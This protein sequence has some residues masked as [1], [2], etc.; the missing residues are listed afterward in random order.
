MTGAKFEKKDVKMEDPKHTDYFSY[1]I[2]DRKIMKSIFLP[3]ASIMN[4]II[5]EEYLMDSKY[6]PRKELRK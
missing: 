6:K 4:M 5:E 1:S 3:K 2:K